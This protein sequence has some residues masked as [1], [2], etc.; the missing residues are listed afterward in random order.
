MMTR[1]QAVTFG[2]VLNKA[3]T[4]APPAA[5][6]LFL[7]TG[8]LYFQLYQ[9]AQQSQVPVMLDQT[10]AKRN[11]TPAMQGINDFWRRNI[12]FDQVHLPTQVPVFRQQ[13]PVTPITSCALSRFKSR[14]KSGRVPVTAT[15]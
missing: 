8:K 10:A 11:L 14:S 12:D 15:S 7:E 4:Q 1:S 2:M 3:Y 5:P 9:Q 6:S 13:R